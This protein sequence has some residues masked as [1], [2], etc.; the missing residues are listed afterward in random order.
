[1]NIKNKKIIAIHN[2]SNY[3]TIDWILGNFCNFK[4]D[5]CFDDFNTGTIRP[6]KIDEKVK[7]NIDHLVKQIKLVNINKKIR[8]NFAGGEPTIFHDFENLILYTKQYGFNSVVTNGSRTINWWKEYKKFIDIVSISYHIQ[9]TNF[10]HVVNVLNEIN[11]D[12][13]VNVMVIF[14]D[15]NFEKCENVYNSL[16]KIILNNNL[17]VNLLIKPLRSTKKRKINYTEDQKIKMLSLFEYKNANFKFSKLDISKNINILFSDNTIIP[18]TM[19]DLISYNDNFIG[20]ECFANKEFIQILQ[21]GEIG[22]MS[23][24][25]FYVPKETNIYSEKFKDEFILTDNPVVCK[26]KRL[27][28]CVG[29]H[30]TT[31]LMTK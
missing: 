15:L 13:I 9:Q 27:C 22:K 3:V 10:D 2:I 18:F 20:Y 6:P 8:F 24:G 7:T 26:Q 5:Y 4:C 12:S 17:S 31:K 23:C 19:K 11:N 14:D 28:G 21:K 16:A 1:M 30:A 25:Q 29:L